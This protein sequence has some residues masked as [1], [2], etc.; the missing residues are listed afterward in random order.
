MF[1]IN[2][3]KNFAIKREFTRLVDN[4]VK[5]WAETAV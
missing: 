3:N 2:E 5:S 4:K 1:F